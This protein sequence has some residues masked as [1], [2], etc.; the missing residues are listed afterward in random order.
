MHPLGITLIA[1]YHWLR[2]CV[3]ALL[4]LLM[5]FA[6]GLASR[7]LSSVEDN[8]RIG[9]ILGGLGIFF[10]A[11]ILLLAMLFVVLGIGI[12]TMK[13]WARLATIVVSAIALLPALFVLLHPRPFGLIRVAINVAIIV[14]L[15]RAEVVQLF[16][17][18]TAHTTQ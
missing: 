10:G 17:R 14:Y 8:P 16:E 12:W 1:I 13:N 11:G 15:L 4:A 9:A 7:F 5:I 6:G 18:G 3:L 2:A